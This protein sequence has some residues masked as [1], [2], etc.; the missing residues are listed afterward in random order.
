[1]LAADRGSMFYAT[2]DVGK[3]RMANTY[4]CIY[5][6]TA[7][8]IESSQLIFVCNFV[9]INLAAGEILAPPNL[10]K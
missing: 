2:T 10:A 1:M 8:V 5:V 7:W 4:V 6:C 9:K 3:A